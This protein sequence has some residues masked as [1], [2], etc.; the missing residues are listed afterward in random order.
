MLHLI[1]HKKH[2]VGNEWIVLKCLRF[3]S[4]QNNKHLHNGA[5]NVAGGATSAI[6]FISSNQEK[7]GQVFAH[8]NWNYKYNTNTKKSDVNF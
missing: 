8:L 7:R 5:G 1:E 2:F 3:S 6:P 4:L